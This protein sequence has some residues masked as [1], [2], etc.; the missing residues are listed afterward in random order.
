V[1]SESLDIQIDDLTI[2]LER[3][4]VLYEQY[5]M[6]FER[7][8]PAI[9]RKDVERRFY[10]LRKVR[11]PTTAKRF[12]FQTLIQRH[13]TLVQYWTR[14][15]REIENGTY[16]K[17][18]I[19]AQKRFANENSR[20][21]PPEAL[22]RAAAAADAKEAAAA[23]LEQM[24]DGDVDLDAELGN[25]LRSLESATSRDK[26]LKRL[27][28]SLVP[29]SASALKGGIRTSPKI[30]LPGLKLSEKSAKAKSKGVAA[31]APLQIRNSKIPATAKRAEDSP[32]VEAERTRSPRDLAAALE[33]Q[34]GAAGKSSP[35]PRLP[36]A[37]GPITLSG[38]PAPPR[39]AAAKAVSPSPRLGNAV[40]PARL[41]PAPQTK[42]PEA[43][44]KA[45]PP[46]QVQP[47]VKPSLGELSEER[48]RTLHAKY[49]DA[50]KQTNAR[51]VSY[52]KLANSIKETEKKLR[53]QHKGRHVDFDVT[54]Q[55]GKAILKPKLK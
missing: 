29:S 17:H 30:L 33:S 36:M 32:P 27:D 38:N 8:E 45:P 16:R 23:D 4:R 19:K 54:I 50:R 14:T 47:T 22:D 37:P 46:L 39:I 26:D 34:S 15:C 25:A 44:A 7:I 11:F 42:H 18:R 12:K 2:R 10:D 5:F 28:G 3:L 40:T 53:A 24:M 48:L 20:S 55:G 31:L 9:P 1:N 51:A 6:G 35:K 43:A 49:S 13:N 52:E 21:E 41:P